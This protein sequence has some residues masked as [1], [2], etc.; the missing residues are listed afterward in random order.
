MKQPKLEKAICGFFEPLAFWFWNR[1]AGRPDSGRLA[2]LSNV[3]DL[4][5]VTSDGRTLQGYKLKSRLQG[6]AAEPR[7]HLLVVPGNAMLSDQLLESFTHFADAGVDVYIFDYRGYGRSQGK[8]RLKAIV[9]D[10]G[11]IIDWLNSMDYTSRLYYAMSFGGIVLLNALQERPADSIVIDSTPSRISKFGCPEAYDPVTNLPSQTG[12]F[13]FIAGAR[14]LIVTPQMS[15]ELVETARLRGA[16]VLLDSDMS[17]PFQDHNLLVRKRR[18]Q[19]VSS[20][21][22]KPITGGGGGEQ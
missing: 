13:L 11:E 1:K 17:H 14:D 19:A 12:R 10:Y 8:R 9:S 21:L 15:R 18:M 22:L 3:E 16:S 2:N 6:T 4:S 7:A 20:F 5:L